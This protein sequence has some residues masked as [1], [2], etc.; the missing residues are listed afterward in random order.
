MRSSNSRRRKCD[1]SIIRA[2]KRAISPLDSSGAKI[3]GSVNLEGSTPV[4]D[5]PAMDAVDGTALLVLVEGR[6]SLATPANCRQRLP[7]INNT[8]RFIVFTMV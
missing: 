7:R 2:A 4:S 6:N 5:V 3:F 1:R 8:Q